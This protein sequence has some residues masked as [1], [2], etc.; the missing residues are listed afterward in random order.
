M[1]KT[2]DYNQIKSTIINWLQA[3]LTQSKC[4]G[5]VVGLSGGVD[6]SVTAVLCR[7]VTSQTL[8][9]LLPCGYTP[10]HAIQDATL[11]A[12]SFEIETKTYDLTDTFEAIQKILNAYETKSVSIPL[13]NVKARLRMIAWYFESNRLNRLVVGAGNRTEIALGYFTK[14]GDAGVDLLPLGALLKRE[15]RELAKSLGIPDK[16]I[17]KPPTPGLW[18]GQTD[19]GELGA[20]YDQLDAF[21]ADEKPKGLSE[22]QLSA[23]RQ[24][25]QLTEHKRQMPPICEIS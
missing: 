15:V 23:L 21:L 24:R 1:A 16:I 6:S 4:H 13:A 3:K 19:E 8:G 5:F 18:P 7:K 22:K 12:K 9:L 10:S 17:S 11:L 25:I 14:Y 20:T 2:R